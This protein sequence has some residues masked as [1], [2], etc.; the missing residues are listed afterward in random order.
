ML[1]V[2]SELSNFFAAQLKTGGVI[3][4][5]MEAIKAYIPLLIEV[6]LCVCVEVQRNVNLLILTPQWPYKLSWF[7]GLAIAKW[8]EGIFNAS[9]EVHGSNGCNIVAEK[10]DPSYV[11]HLIQLEK[12]IFY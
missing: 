6:R 12:K 5:K 3:A 9:I 4:C 7:I 11:S 8:F 2:F 10:E 1:Y